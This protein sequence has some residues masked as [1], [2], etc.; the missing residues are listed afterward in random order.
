MLKTFLLK[1]KTLSINLNGVLG[2][3]EINMATKL[4][5]FEVDLF[6]KNLLNTL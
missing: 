6:N 4:H 5:I 3:I 1:V 2:N